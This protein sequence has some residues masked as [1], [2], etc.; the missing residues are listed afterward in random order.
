MTYSDLLLFFLSFF[1]LLFEKQRQLI[2]YKFDLFK[3]N[4]RTIRY[5]MLVQHFCAVCIDSE[6]NCCHVEPVALAV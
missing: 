5:Y 2:N 6:S 3:G 4:F 1:E